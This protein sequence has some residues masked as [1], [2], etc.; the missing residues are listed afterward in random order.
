MLKRKESHQNEMEFVSIEE[1]VPKDH[2]L[3]KIDKLTDLSFIYNKVEHLYCSDNG[4]PPIDPVP[5]FKMLLIGYL[6]G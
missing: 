1:L 6:F 2:L 4:S 5:L 3:R